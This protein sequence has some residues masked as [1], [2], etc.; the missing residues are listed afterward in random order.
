VHALHSATTG[1]SKK[2]RPKY[3]RSNSRLTIVLFSG[4]MVCRAPGPVPVCFPSAPRR[5]GPETLNIEVN[6]QRILIFISGV[7][8]MASKHARP[9]PIPPPPDQL[10]GHYV[11]HGMWDGRMGNGY[12][13]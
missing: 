7:S 8:Q 2:S 12:R 9:D 10:P 11:G 1:G 13:E 4:A 6:S 3:L 5:P